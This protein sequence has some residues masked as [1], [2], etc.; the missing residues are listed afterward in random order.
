MVDVVVVLVLVTVL[1][2]LFALMLTTVVGVV[3]VNGLIMIGECH[4]GY[5]HDDCD[6]PLAKMVILTSGTR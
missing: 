1:R 4:E 3:V 5:I 2:L 6:V